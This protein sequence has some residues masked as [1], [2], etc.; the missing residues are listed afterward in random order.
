MCFM[1]MALEPPELAGR[2]VCDLCGGSYGTAVRVSSTALDC[3]TENLDRAAPGS[4][5]RQRLRVPTREVAYRV[6]LIT[7]GM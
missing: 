1:R 7:M 6:E 5:Q 3:Y 4:Q 2:R